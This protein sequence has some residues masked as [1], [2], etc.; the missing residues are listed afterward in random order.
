MPIQDN[1]RHS[2]VGRMKK[3]RMYPMSMWE[4]NGST[5]DVSLSDLFNQKN[6]SI[7]GESKYSLGDITKIICKGGWP[8]VVQEE[9]YNKS[10]KLVDNYVNELINFE[11]HILDGIRRDP[12]TARSILTSYA[13]SISTSSSLN[14]LTKN[15]E[16]IKDWRTVESYID[17]FKK[18]YIIDEVEA[19]EPRLLSKAT[20]RKSSTRQLVD[21]SI[22][23]SILELTPND[24][25]GDYDR[26]NFLFKSLVTRDLRIYSSLISGSVYKYSDSTGLG[27]DTIIQLNNGKWGAIK[28]ILG[29][30][31]TIEYGVKALLLLKNKVDLNEIGEPSFL[32]I[33]TA[34]SCSY[35]R[36]D[37]VYVIPIGCLKN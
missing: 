8:E 31:E 37:G 32:A 28:I 30:Q 14:T 7:H 2:G 13:R 29:D 12:I 17:A 1:N 4:S 35:K 10:S 22:A 27:I 6:I 23:T 24:L 16:S 18:L 20:I 36:K 25:I 5:G 3:I 11:I 15:I 9:D 34:I 19:W 21:P 33:I 26:F